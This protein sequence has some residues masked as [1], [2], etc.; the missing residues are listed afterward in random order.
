MGNQTGPRQ[1]E[2]PPNMS[3]VASPGVYGTSWRWP[4]WTKTKGF[5]PWALLSE[6]M[7]KLE[8]NSLGSSM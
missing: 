8:R 1:L 6:R 4:S 3:V 7:P 2:F 5:A